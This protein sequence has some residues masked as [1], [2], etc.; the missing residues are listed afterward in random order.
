M[1]LFDKLRGEFIDIIEWTAPSDS[2]V[3]CYRFPRH[4]NEIK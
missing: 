2:D 4:N 1:G 3:L